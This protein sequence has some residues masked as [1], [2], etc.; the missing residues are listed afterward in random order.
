MSKKYGILNK[1]LIIS[2]S[3]LF[4]G[5]GLLPSISGNNN[6]QDIVTITFYT[7]DRTR[8][9]NRMVE[10][11]K[12]SVLEITNIFDELK[13]KI[14]IDPVSSE[15]QAL[16][17]DFVETLDSYGLIPK[18]SSRDEIVSLLNPRWLGLKK[19]TSIIN[20]IMPDPILHRGSSAFCS[21]AGGGSGLIF[22][23]VM[24]PRPRLAT[25]WSA[26]MGGIM[27][28]ANLLTGHGYVAYGAQ[29]GMA[30]G[31][32]GL[33]LSYAFPG[34]PAVFGLGG[35]A[36]FSMASAEEV[37]LYPE[38]RAPLI[39]SENPSD[40]E[41]DVSISTSELSFRISDADRDRMSYWVSTEPDIGSGEGHQKRDGVYTVPISGLE[42]D[43]SYS[44]TIR[45]SD[46]KDTVEKKNGFLTVMGPPYNPF[47]EGWSYRKKITI[48]HSQVAGDLFDFPVLISMVDS[49]LANKAQVDGDDILFM[50]G[51]G[52]AN[53]LYHEIEKY[54]S[55][56]G[57]LITW[58][59]IP[60]ISSVDDT[61]LYIYYGNGVCSPQEFGERTWNG[62]FLT[63]LHMN[64][65]SGNPYDSSVY[66]NTWKV[67]NGGT[68]TY[69]STGKI[70]YA[71]KGEHAENDGNHFQ[72]TG[73]M[74]WTDLNAVTIEL[75]FASEDITVPSYCF[76][77]DGD[78]HEDIRFTFSSSEKGDSVGWFN[79]WDDGTHRILDGRIFDW[80][81]GEFHYEAAIMDNTD[82][83]FQGL[84]T[85][86]DLTVSNSPSDFKFSNL[87]NQFYIGSRSPERGKDNNFGGWLDEF[88]I[89]RV[90]RSDAWISTSYN[91]IN[92]PSSFFNI[93]PEETGP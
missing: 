44:W 85:D 89:S 42:Y 28:A 33:G 18:G 90:R 75:W 17:N 4:I 8:I 93:G 40:G 47:D 41:W 71:I 58:V 69:Q 39:S 48:D 5:A 11:S 20:N 64:D 72:N 86:G 57:E 81:N 59:N 51:P 76:G 91:T 65:F 67:K 43:K 46:G 21:I 36:L 34:E 1:T 37:E 88:R 82:N 26:H 19:N 27:T 63:V 10:L 62:D 92:D 55:S 14:T 70:G 15:T 52:I 49:D 66:H 30:L 29:F 79:N 22:P 73:E 77:G 54:E 60:R 74:D 38:N 24:L 53:K 87:N 31:F 13:E 80:N 23:P 12:N 6:I 78:N 2:I 32:M 68:L 7:F 61:I 45:V 16:K 35:Y 56:S 3:L 83:N 84:Y 9:N 50:D 25:F